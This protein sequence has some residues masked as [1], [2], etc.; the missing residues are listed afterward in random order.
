[1]KNRLLAAAT[2]V[3]AAALALAGCTSGGSA[4]TSNGTV[5]LTMWMYGGCNDCVEKPLVAAFEKQNPNI[6]IKLVQEPGNSYFAQLQSAS[7]TGSGPDIAG[8]FAGSYMDKFKKYM[9]DERKYLPS[10]LIDQAP[11]IDYFSAD[12]SRKNAVYG[13]PNEDQFYIGYYNKK[14]FAENGISTPPATWDQLMADCAILKKA[15]VLPIAY[16]GEDGGATMAPIFDWAYLA[17]ALPI[18]KWSDLLN[19]KM[20]YDTP[21]LQDQLTKWNQLF[22]SGYVNK[23]GYN[24]PNVQKEFTTGKAAMILSDGSWDVPSYQKAMGDNLG[25]IAP[26]YTDDASTHNLVELA[27]NGYTIMKY[28]KHQAE[29][30]KFVS[31]ILSDA[32]QKVVAETGQPAIRPGFST[33]YAALNA[34]TALSDK[35]GTTHYPM[36]DNFSQSAVTTV[37]NS[38][39]G[40]VLFGQATPSKALK[41]MDAAVSSLPSDQQNQ[42]ISF[43]G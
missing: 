13:V 6:K 14:I 15:G 25:V 38:T 23:N 5:N 30:G 32:G 10:K 21:V 35:S 18:S 42:H 7:V 40:Q 41:A 11:S 19:G 26:P 22:Q 4:S 16:G 12:Y 43:S 20:K 9:V 31:F 37:I 36:Y 2:A 1:M 8:M 39:V 27:G 29:A 24:D 33:Q 28:S 17:A 3:V 34:L